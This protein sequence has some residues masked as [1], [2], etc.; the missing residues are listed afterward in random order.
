[1][2]DPN[3]SRHPKPNTLASPRT[4]PAKVVPMSDT[5]PLHDQIRAGLAQSRTGNPQRASVEI[6]M[7]CLECKDLDRA[8]QSR[9]AKYIE[10]RTAA[11]YRVSTE[12]AAKKNV[13]ME[14][15]KTDL[16]EHQSACP[17]TAKVRTDAV[18]LFSDR[19]ASL[20]G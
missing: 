20:K 5:V 3:V 15:A 8:F 16:Q 14:R 7:N 12:L 13:D 9:L 11:F 19:L 2:F 17:F 10:A 18:Q 6:S 1:M 4:T